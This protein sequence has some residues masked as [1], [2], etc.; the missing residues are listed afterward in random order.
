MSR[1]TD[2]LDGTAVLTWAREG[3]RALG[4]ARRAL[5]RVNVFPVPDADTGTNMYLTF[6][7]GARA[8]PAERCGGA[9]AG[10][11][12]ALLAR[13][14]LVGA[15]G[16]SGV[17][18]SEYLRGLA[19]ALAGHDAV[20]APALAEGL[21]AAART[22]RGAVAHPVAG[23]ILTAADAAARSAAEAVPAGVAGGRAEV[24]LVAS[25]ARDGARAAALRSRG[26]LDVLA[27]AEVLDAG[28]LG[29]TVLL[30]ALHAAVRG[31]EDAD[32]P[33]APRPAGVSEVLAIMAT[34]ASAPP[35]AVD[36]GPAGE[37][38]GSAA[39][40]EG[41]EFE[42]MYV[43]DATSV[44]PGSPRLVADRRA[45]GLAARLRT[46]LAEVGGSV[47]VVGGDLAAEPGDEQG[48]EQGGDGAPH[49]ALGGVWQAHVHT[50]DPVAAVAAG[51]AALAEVPGGAVLRQVRVRHLVRQESVAPLVDDEP[52]PPSDASPVGVVAVTTAPG[53]VADLAR[54]G[55]VVLLQ[56]RGA[57]TDVAALHRAV[58]D[59]GASD[60][61][62]LPCAALGAETVMGLREAARAD[63]VERLDVL[64]APTDLHVV[65]ALAASQLVEAD[66][67]SRVEAAR[68]AATRARV[69]R[70]AAPAGW[71]GSHAALPG[72]V[73]TALADVLDGPAE[74]L[75][76][77]ADDDVPGGLV[78]AV[79]EHAEGRGAEAVVLRSGR[80]GGTMTLGA[81]PPDGGDDEHAEET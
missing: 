71:D 62:V 18:L 12:L 49:E 51:H 75:T 68:T 36:V 43:L 2:V 34:T 55:A 77:L 39:H 61:V 46:G 64:A 48:G 60:V 27:R 4:A 47:V 32:P 14:A 15:R 50:D 56:E 53:L 57:L 1:A 73:A 22:A 25:A 76:V 70:T 72:V 24:A 74:V 40:D 8:L 69:V 63:G 65:A 10:A 37:A 7:D 80:P 42:V 66:G 58:V 16:N 20:P 5:D 23:T 54:A 33:A 52:A 6:L 59:T 29:L 30:S 45:P 44:P 17:I 31:A 11:L 67:R 78:D 3:V 79:A 41:G 21:A 38:H 81:E 13:G 28:A 9:G 26:E 19:V 35:V